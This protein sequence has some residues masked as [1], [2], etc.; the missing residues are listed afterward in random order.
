MIPLDD[1]IILSKEETLKSNELIIPDSAT[2]KT[3]VE[4]GDI[5]VA[6]KLGPSVQDRV[7]VGDRLLFYGMATVMALKLPKGQKCWVGRAADVAFKLEKG[8]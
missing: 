7:S 8:D 2:D 3:A 1:W 5:F 6:E 4:V